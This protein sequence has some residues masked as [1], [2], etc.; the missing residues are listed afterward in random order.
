MKDLL[1]KECVV[2]SSKDLLLRLCS[3]YRIPNKNIK[4]SMFDSYR[5]TQ[6]PFIISYEGA[7][8]CE[9]DVSN[10]LKVFKTIDELRHYLFIKKLLKGKII[11][12]KENY[13]LYLKTIRLL[14]KIGI[15]SIKNK[16][17]YE[18]ANAFYVLQGCFRELSYFGCKCVVSMTNG[19]PFKAGEFLNEVKTYVK[20]KRRGEIDE[21]I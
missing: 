12:Y 6:L 16:T 17:Y 19:I 3:E 4:S 1:E 14:K 21:T 5:L 7:R 9:E 18:E 10:N 11:V 2:V 13:R 15:K 20:A 8:E